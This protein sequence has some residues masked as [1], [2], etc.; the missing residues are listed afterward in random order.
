MTGRT[1][2]TP[3][4]G[5]TVVCV[6]GLI[7]HDEFILHEVETVR[8]GVIRTIYHLLDCKIGKKNEPPCGKTNNVVFEQVLHKLGCTS[9]EDG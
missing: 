9:T 3:H 7:V 4:S 6:V 2:S 1:L 8:S 5:T